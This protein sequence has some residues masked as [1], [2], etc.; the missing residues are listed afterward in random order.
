[1]KKLLTIFFLTLSITFVKAQTTGNGLI[2][3][4]A[5]P[6][7]FIPTTVDS[8]TTIDVDFIN[9]ATAPQTLNLTGLLAPFSIS[10]SSVLINSLDTVTLQLSFTPTSVA[11][12]TDTLD[13]NGSIFGSGSLALDGEGVQVSLSVSSDT[14]D[15]G[16]LSLGTS[17]TQ[18]FDLI[19]TGTGTMNISNINSTNSQVTVDTM[20]L[21]I[22]QGA[23]AT[24]SV[25]Y[26]PTISG[27]LNATL[28]IYSNDPNNPMY[29]ITILGSAVSQVSGNICNDIWVPTNNPYLFTDNVYIPGGC[30][31]E[32]Q[33][34][35][36]VDMNGYQLKSVW[37]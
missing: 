7:S 23:S 24:I 32:I 11:N 6:Y 1:M 37:Q 33:P 9:M 21:Q 19:N 8:T 31:L 22:A 10:S 16:I 2:A 34:G 30:Q 26:A 3:Q 12:F 5:S 13:W 25:T 29:P 15:M 27:V 20:S 14:L 36:V 35:T 17:T 28:E 4:I 18:T